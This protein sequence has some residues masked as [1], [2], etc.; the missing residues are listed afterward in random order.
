MAWNSTAGAQSRSRDTGQTRIRYDFLRGQTTF[1]AVRVELDTVIAS[2]GFDLAPEFL[3]SVLAR[4]GPRVR[5]AVYLFPRSLGRRQFR[6][7][8]QSAGC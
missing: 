1:S 3:Y 5:L 7:Q 2:N 4:E 8:K 6:R